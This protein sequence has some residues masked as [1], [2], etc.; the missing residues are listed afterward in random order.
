[1][2]DTPMKRTT[3]DIIRSLEMRVAKLEKRYHKISRSYQPSENDAI[4]ESLQLTEYR[5]WNILKGPERMSYLRQVWD[6]Y[7]TTYKKIGITVK[8]PKVLI[9]K[10][11]VWYIHFDDGVP[12]AFNLFKPTSFGMK[13]GLSG[14]DGS[15]LGRGVSKSWIKNRWKTVNGFYGEVSGA[16]EYIS[17]KSGAPVVCNAYVETV[18]GKTPKGLEDDNVHYVRSFGGHNHTKIM[19]GNPRGVKSIPYKDALVSCPIP[20]EGVRVARHERTSSFEDR[21]SHDCSIYENSLFGR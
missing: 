14:N 16:V 4:E 21:L 20:T 3:S 15:S 18:L 11:K 17:I 10:Y 12:V 7:T 2:K 6:M 1:M 19:I 9:E 8:A 5:G 13:T